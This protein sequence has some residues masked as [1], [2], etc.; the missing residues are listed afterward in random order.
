MMPPEPSAQ[1]TLEKAREQEKRYDWLAAANSYQQALHV[2]SSM[3]SSAL[4]IWERIG[5]CY[6]LASR[7]TESLEEFKKLTQL[8]VKAYISAAELLEKDRKAKS[9][10][11][12]L[13]L[14]AVAEYIRSWVTSSPSEKREV[15]ANSS[16]LAKRSLDAYRSA[17]D[18]LDCG[19]TSN[20]ILMCLLERLYV[21]SDSEEMKNVGQEGID[22]A[23]QVITILSKFEDK[24]ELLRACSTAGLLGWHVA[25]FVE[26]E[27]KAQKELVERSLSYSEKALELS[28]HVDNPYYTAL[29]NWAAALCTLVFTEKAELA[30]QYAK[31]MLEQG[32]NV[33]DNYLKGVASYVLAFATDWMMIRETDPDRKKEGNKKIINY[34]EDA[35]R[36]LQLVGQ[37][38]FIAETYMFY[39]ESYFALGLDVE[40]SPVERRI[41]L[42][43]AVD[44]GRKGLEHAIRSGSP[45]ARGSTLHAL[46]KALHFYSNIETR[47]E[48]KTRLLQEA[49]DCRKEFDEIVQK[50]FPSNDWLIG[51]NKNYQGS[52]KVDLARVELDHDKKRVLLESAVSDIEDGISH[53]RRWI[54]F[55]P[56]P[57]QIATV[58]S[59]EDEFGTILSDLY[60]LTKD[61]IAL[62]RA[63]EAHESAARQFKKAGMPSR[64]AESCWKMARD[65][66]RLG[67]YQKATENFENASSEYT[68]AAQNTPNFAN[69]YQDHASYM[70]AWSEI[71]KASVAH[72]C[73]NYAD[74]MKHYETTAN[75][76]K[77]TKSWRYLSSNFFGWSHLEQ[78]EDLSRKENSSESI[79]VFEKSAEFFKE[80]KEAF[81][82]EMDKIQNLDEKEMAIELGKASMRREHYCLARIEV[83]EAKILDRK[84][85]HTQ[86]AEKYDSAANAFE[87]ILDTMETEADRRE[88]EPFYY[89]CRA[90]Q[91]MKIADK[92]ASP[93]LYREASELFLKAKEHSTKDRTTLLAS[94]NSAF[95]KALEHGTEFE[96]TREKDHFSKTKQYLESAADYYLRAGFDNA[97]V[98]TSATEML[99]DAYNYMI[100]AE[101]KAD[102]QKKMKIYLLAEK[103]LERSARLYG[104]AGY[105]AKKEEVLK[106]LRK[107]VEKREFALS[108]GELFTA[109]NDASSTRA[110]SAPRLTVEE[111]VGLL[112]FEHAFL[113]AN[114]ILDK[115]EILVG[116]SLSLEVQLVN[117]GK[118]SAFLTRAEEI[119]P[120]GF[121]VI[122]KPEKCAVNDRFLNLKGRKLGPLETDEIR[123]KLRPRK[124]GEFTFAPTIQFIDEAGEHKSSKL[125][126]VTVSVKEMGIR[127]WLKGQ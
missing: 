96:A 55:R 28:K 38:F 70:K 27:E 87:K 78:A 66:D 89:L 43:K 82:K 92:S 77:Q 94:G 93:E 83:E 109:P 33:R 105:F 80:A 127:S 76:L 74:A 46:S 124:K 86:S 125:E 103:C 73:E 24:G 54:S 2:D 118:D 107:V 90:W 8:A 37:D 104:E 19:R 91:K 69:F 68:V 58:G 10:G 119:F 39:A 100:S 49:L 108:L 111:P 52:I 34:A 85:N 61:K 11:K 122:E 110:I 32:N 72:E 79:E 30:L 50:A 101:L 81:E 13:Q 95:C 116:E 114:L 16:E 44:I 6:Q 22:C 41:A 98:W 88:M 97:S 5:F 65:Q 121:D 53:C 102:P 62:I 18:E 106:T 31:R 84:G 60:L 36:Y 25:N 75:L 7:Q 51:V 115:K 12:S 59:F 3:V 48:E 126:Q 4:E 23:N 64:V 113:Q 67:E 20:D 63:I 123:V 21:A 29:S 35:I 57:T 45:D 1:A 112:K 17:C 14:Y 99:F 40:T 42:E 9:Q 56:V 117:S 71:E 15:L 26:L 47:K 120:E